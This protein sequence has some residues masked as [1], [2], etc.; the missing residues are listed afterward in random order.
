M[1]IPKK[2]WCYLRILNTQVNYLGPV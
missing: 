1:K 2:F